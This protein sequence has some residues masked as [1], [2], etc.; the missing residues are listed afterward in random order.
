MNAVASF[1]RIVRFYETHDAPDSQCPHC[2]ATGRYILTFQVEDGRRLARALEVGG[3]RP[4]DVLLGG[5][6]VPRGLGDLARMYRELGPGS[7]RDAVLE[8]ILETCLSWAEAE[9][10][11]NCDAGPWPDHDS[12]CSSRTS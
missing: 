8:A 4:R 2:G 10:R 11:C 7:T 1:P 5:R 3:L 9:E 6:V 12:R